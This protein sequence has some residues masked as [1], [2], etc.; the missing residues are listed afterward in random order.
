MADVKMADF[1]LQYFMQLR[2]NEMPPEVR[3]QYDAYAKSDD[4]RGHMKEWKA[5]LAGH[6]LPDPNGPDYHLDEDEWKELFREFQS[7][8]RKMDTNRKNFVN[9]VDF[10]INNKD[11]IEFLDEYFGA[12]K[13][14]D[15][16]TASP[17]AEAQIQVLANVLNSY[18][19]ILEIQFSEWG[20]TGGDFSYNDLT[21]G[22]KDKKY[23]TDSDFQTKVKNVAYYLTAYTTNPYYKNDDLI[24]ALGG[25]A[26]DFK[27][28]QEGFDDK[29]VD[30]AKLNAFKTEYDILLRTLAHKD[31]IR[32]V[33]PSDK[34][35]TAFNTA[36]ENV[37]YDD[38]NSK[39]YV[40]P[41]RDDELTPL[42]QLSRWADD[43][44]AD[45]FEKY[46]K[47]KGDRLYFSPQAKQIVAAIH[48]A[49][50]KPTDGIKGVMDKAGDIEKGLLYK[51]PKATEHF[52]WF[53]KTMGELSNTMPKAFEGALRNGRQ[54][55]AIIEEM[56][57]IAVRDGKVDEAKSAM[58]V[59]SVIKYGY[60][61][62]K[63][64]DA[65][66]K[67]K[68]SIFSDGKLSW[69]KNEGMKFVTTA[70]D[71]SIKTA[72]MGIGYGI[73]VV[74]NAIN[75]SGSKFN[76][77]R[78]RMM[79]KQQEWA[80][81]NAADKAAAQ[82]RR[83]T[84]NTQDQA[85]IQQENQ[86][87]S[88]VNQ[89]LQPG[90]RT[91][92]D[93]NF[94]QQKTD[95]ETARTAEDAEKTRLEQRAQDP[96][97][98][99]SAQRVNDYNNLLQEQTSYQQNQPV[100]TQQIAD[101]D[102]QIQAIQTDP[103]MSQTEKD[104]R[105]QG[106]IQ[107]KIEK[108]NQLAQINQRLADIPNELNAITTNPNWTNDQHIVQQHQAETQAYN[109]TV[110]QNNAQEDRIKK[111]E[112]ATKSIEE[113]NE[114]ISKR[115]EVMD[116]WDD[117][118]KDKYLELMAYWD[119]LETGRNTHMGKMYNWKP[120]KAGNAQKKFDGQKQ[121]IISDYLSGYSYAA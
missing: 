115:D 10:G 62:S 3:A 117:N 107:N 16:A 99:A 85:L 34:I 65:L 64:M 74:G 103:N 70:L 112:N 76:G 106:L 11:A 79:D 58:E 89:N 121:T 19:N 29:A 92:T 28:I 52:K 13:L 102:N 118:H 8:F 66:G 45:V 26:F 69:N 43:T 55:H 71:K 104:M 22:I 48:K 37:A 98:M 67:E 96:A 24:R 40:P 105:S 54:M 46:I 90:Q 20:L 72:F 2:F 84:L 25:N 101:L 80:T 60:T 91:I 18:K 111:W 116:K 47:F 86:N 87:K 78:G 93:A 120:I 57:M 50:V 61:T 17:A 114:R 39:D 68:L 5:R 7:A 15:K 88:D 113:I 77:R 119:M 23:N 38:K 44:Y 110:D 1:L 95:L 53:T 30:P 100:L 31:K 97:Y 56:I 27:D 41:K 42:Q 36:K 4:F 83:N 14:F 81:Q 49:K 109:N 21:K 32:D 12:G 33:F 108:Q 51:S 9:A 35:K 63:I 75:L 59:L 6:D 73:T 82:T 94:Q